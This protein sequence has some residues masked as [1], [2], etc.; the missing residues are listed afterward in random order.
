MV[1]KLNPFLSSLLMTK[2]CIFFF[3]SFS[4]FFQILEH[5]QKL[6]TKT[7]R[8]A[9]KRIFRKAV[10]SFELTKGR[11]ISK[12]SFGCLQISQKTN[13]SISVLASNK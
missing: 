10:V 3:G 2:R 11:L 1:E 6:R 12:C 7:A 9:E 13:K 8:N 4:D 5:L